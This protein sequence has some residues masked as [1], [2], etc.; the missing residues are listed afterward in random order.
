MKQVSYSQEQKLEAT[1]AYC[2]LG[3]LLKVAKQVNM[4]LATLKDWS[5]SAWWPV[6]LDKARDLID[7][8]FKGKLY[9]INKNALE[10]LKDRIDNG[11]T[12][13]SVDKHGDKHEYRLPLKGKELAGIYKT[14]QEQLNLLQK[15]PTSISEQVSVEKRLNKL[16]DTFA[17]ISEQDKKSTGK[18]L[19]H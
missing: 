8:K 5:R 3:S 2:L 14:T 4:P 19:V 9:G 16:S 12:I 11:D 10:E 7:A 17:A 15:R 18:E 1:Y 13:I 6:F